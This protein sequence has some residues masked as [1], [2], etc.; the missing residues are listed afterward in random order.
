MIRIVVALTLLF[1]SIAVVAQSAA[2]KLDTAKIDSVLGRSGTW[3]YGNYVVT[4]LRPNLRVTL[5]G[6]QLAPGHVHS[7][8][9]FTGTDQNAE[10]MGDVCAVAEEV[11]AAVQKLRSSGIQVTGIHGHFLGESPTLTFVHFL[12]H[13]SA[14]ELA[15]AFRTALTATDTPLSTTPSARVDVP[16]A[17]LPALQ[18]ALGRQVGYSVENRLASAKVPRADMPPSAMDYWYASSLNFQDAPG[19]QVL[20]IGDLALTAEEVNPALS[21][22]TQHGFHIAALHNHSLDEQPRL[23]FLHFWKTGTPSEVGEGIKVALTG[24]RIR[25][26]GPMH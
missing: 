18:N 2:D 15:R 23:F 10:M 1:A 13:G 22:L 25:R 19:G 7:F 5:A 12:G 17:W 26:P 3:S 11:T 21:V 8:A 24:L 16:P 4:F 6:V 9:T 14:P 20:A